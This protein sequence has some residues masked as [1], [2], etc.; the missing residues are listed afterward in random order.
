MNKEKT[1]MV[2]VSEMMREGSWPIS[3]RTVNNMIR[4]GKIKA[5][6]IGAGG[7]RPMW[8]VT[9]DEAR[10]MRTMLGVV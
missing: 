10:R 3:R 2:K 6:N 9:E 1:G 8:A 7:T 5:V 4:T